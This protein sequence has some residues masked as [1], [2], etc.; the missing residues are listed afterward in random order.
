MRFGDRP[1]FGRRVLR[2]VLSGGGGTSRPSRSPTETGKTGTRTAAGARD[3]S[4]TETGK[5]GTR[6]AAGARDRSPT[7]VP[8]NGPPHP[9]SDTPGVR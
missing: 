8:S 5:T 7:T 2:G 3:R 9:L 6:T 4:P 1:R